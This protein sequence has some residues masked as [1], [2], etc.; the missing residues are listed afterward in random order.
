MIN[1]RFILFLLFLFL[2]LLIGLTFSQSSKSVYLLKDL[3][4]NEEVKKYTEKFLKDW[5]KLKILE[6]KGASEKEIN[7]LKSLLLD[8]IQELKNLAEKYGEAPEFKEI[9]QVAENKLNVSVS[10]VLIMRPTLLRKITTTL[11]MKPLTLEK[12]YALNIN[13]KIIN[14][15]LVIYLMWKNPGLSPDE[16]VE[17]LKE[18]YT[19]SNKAIK[20]GITENHKIVAQEVKHAE[21]HFYIEYTLGRLYTPEDYQKFKADKNKLMRDLFNKIIAEKSI[22]FNNIDYIKLLGKNKEVNWN[23]VIVAYVDN[24]P[25]YLNE[26][27]SIYPSFGIE[28][29]LG[30]TNKNEII[31]Q[32]I[33]LKYLK[34]LFLKL[35]QNDS[36][37]V[38][39]A[40]DFIKRATIA[41]IFYSSL[42]ANKLPKYQIKID[43]NEIK[44]YYESNINKFKIETKL[45]P[46]EQVRGDIEKILIRSKIPKLIRNI[47]QEET[48][49][50][51]IEIN[52][53]LLKEITNE[54]I[55]NFWKTRG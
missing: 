17:I 41:K 7:D 22:K 14:K 53:E 48:S 49:A 24:T 46:L 50:L 45:L 51:R 52:S 20:E 33:Q 39:N 26:V 40:L 29:F 12:E 4:K 1:K 6:S 10:K 37:F 18:V 5:E 23:S 16:T 42:I 30:S 43:E 19:I 38:N 34:N 35:S 36:I 3:A 9:L 8:E 47:Y 44:T 27:L 2:L 25:I 32:A 31:L 11:A 21:E 15:D 54:E 13:N 55:R 28:I